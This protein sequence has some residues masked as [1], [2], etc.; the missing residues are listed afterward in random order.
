MKQHQH[1]FGQKSN[2][3][4]NHSGQNY[5]KNY[6]SQNW[7][8]RSGLK[9]NPVWHDRISL[10]PTRKSEQKKC[11]NWYHKTNTFYTVSNIIE[12]DVSEIYLG[13]KDN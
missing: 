8:G 11:N 7:Y 2:R 6:S 4:W 3:E 10:L 1:Y 12:C 9:R 13:S 5:N